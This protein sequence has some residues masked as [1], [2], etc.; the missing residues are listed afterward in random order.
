LEAILE[1]MMAQIRLRDE[2]T[3]SAKQVK[4][5]HI[6]ECLKMVRELGV[7]KNSQ[8]YYV[9]TKLFKKSYNREIFLHY[10]TPKEKLDFL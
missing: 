5:D 4:P 7:P 3:K 2:A 6:H 9:A 1:K 10:D 8:E